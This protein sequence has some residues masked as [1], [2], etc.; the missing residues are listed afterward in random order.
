MEARFIVNYGCNYD[1]WFCHHEGWK[2]EERKNAGYMD[3]AKA[4]NL[5]KILYDLGYRRV[6]FSGGEPTLHPFLNDLV[7]EAHTLGFHITVVTNGS[8]LQR[9]TTYEYIDTLNISIH[10]FDNEEYKLNTHNKFEI[11]T[12][13]ENINQLQNDYPLLDLRVN[14]VINTY[15]KDHL[16]E[17]LNSIKKV[18]RIKLIEV[19][20]LINPELSI[21]SVEKLINDIG[22]ERIKQ[23]TNRRKVLYNYDESEIMLTRVFCAQVNHNH[24]G[25]DFCREKNEIS[26]SPDFY[27]KKCRSQ[28]GIKIDLSNEQKAREVISNTFNLLGVQCQ[29]D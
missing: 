3:F 24:L 12:I 4:V 23:D 28:E 5:L 17:V 2:D 29:Y 7:R 19:F 20:P 27:V 21:E 22:L 14:T 6:T 13:I 26:I 25:I 15:L 11:H 9:I 18:K 16:I 8:M 10:T 1:C